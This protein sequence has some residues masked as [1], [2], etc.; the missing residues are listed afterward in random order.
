MARAKIDPMTKSNKKPITIQAM[1]ADAVVTTS[2]LSAHTARH[3]G[4]F[5]DAGLRFRDAHM[6]LR[7]ITKS[8][9]KRGLGW[10]TPAEAELLAAHMEDHAQ[11]PTPSV[12]KWL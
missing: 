6:E 1:P 5:L 8:D 12:E 3:G 4:S 7:V 10:V 11:D 9:H 2:L